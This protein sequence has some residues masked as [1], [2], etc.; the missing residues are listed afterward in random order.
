MLNFIF[1]FTI[2]F[3][4]SNSISKNV[5][6]F[7]FLFFV[8]RWCSFLFLRENPLKFT[9]NTFI[10]FHNSQYIS[11]YLH[12]HLSINVKDYWRFLLLFSA[13]FFIF[14]PARLLSRFCFALLCFLF[15]FRSRRY[16][17]FISKLVHLSTMQ[18]NVIWKTI[19]FWNWSHR[20]RSILLCIICQ[21]LKTC[22]HIS[23]F[24]RFILWR[25]RQKKNEKKKRKNWNKKKHLNKM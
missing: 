7:F 25:R 19:C 24:L 17:E 9:C 5:F 20:Y 4:F 8:A 6:W 22:L 23:T 1:F 18:L 14:T 2:L 10:N 21:Y 13:F 12:Y 3:T 15:Y 11:K 16:F